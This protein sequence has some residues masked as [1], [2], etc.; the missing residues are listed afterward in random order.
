MA[1]SFLKL[2][3]SELIK[4]YTDLTDDVKEKLVKSAEYLS[5]AGFT[6]LQELGST[7]LHSRRDLFLNNISV[8]P[9]EAGVY[10]ITVHQDAVWIEDGM[11]PHSM[12]EDLL[13][14]PKAKTAKDGSKYIIVPFRHSKAP[15]RST[16]QQKALLSAIKDE[17]K[18]RDIPYK[19]IEKNPDGSPKM[20]L[21]HSFDI[22]KPEQQNRVPP[23][24]L[25]PGGDQ[26][27][28]NPIPTGQ[29][30]PGGRPYLWGTKV[31]QS[32]MKNQNGDV[33]M[34]SS[35]YPKADRNIF[36]FRVASSKQEGK[37]NH[38]GL[39][40]QHFLEDTYEWVKQ[41][42]EDQIL[43]EILSSINK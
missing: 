1:D 18:S 8:E 24:E 40:P 37:W 21:L 2:D 41:Q 9:L 13:T 33:Q 25:G 19:K 30:G 17:L 36:T 34:D 5:Q 3:L 15:S 10:A 28:A 35:G 32:P 7:K 43:P 6:H 27:R 22:A 14:S 20:G 4:G 39:S 23:G 11:P 31:Y 38:P 26:F 16:P 29:E 12:L 42:W